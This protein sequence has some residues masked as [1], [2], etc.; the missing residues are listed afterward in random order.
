MRH[1]CSN[2]RDASNA[3]REYIAIPCH[4]LPTNNS[5][6]LDTV[7][8]CKLSS[9]S[10]MI[11][12]H[13]TRQHKCILSWRT[14]SLLLSLVCSNQFHSCLIDSQV[15]S[16]S[17]GTA[18]LVTPSQTNKRVSCHVQQFRGVVR[19]RNIKWENQPLLMHTLHHWAAMVETACNSK[20]KIPIDATSNRKK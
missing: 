16:K 13:T 7:W 10:C 1:I 5:I 4:T 8:Q 18:Y 2:A 6:S 19:G 3:P 11:H 12:T 15:C 9:E 17:L 14:R 20:N